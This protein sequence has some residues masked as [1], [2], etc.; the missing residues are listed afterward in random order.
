MRAG[1]LVLILSFFFSFNLDAQD[2][3]NKD[4]AVEVIEDFKYLY[5]YQNFYLGGQPTLEAMKWLKSQGVNKIIN[6]RTDAENNEFSAIAFHEEFN[7]KELGFE[8]HS[9]PVH[10]SNDYTPEMLDDFSGNLNTNEKTFI[11]CRT[12]GRVTHFFMAFLIMER[13]YGINEAV[14][15]GKDLRFSFPLEDLLGTEIRMEMIDQNIIG[16]KV[17]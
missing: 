5:R 15:I 11:H 14:K 3:I 6:L 2:C 4:D 17:E 1:K 9:I 10:G 13:E 12:G 8:Y 7:A 16:Y